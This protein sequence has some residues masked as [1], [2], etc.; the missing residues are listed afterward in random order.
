VEEGTEEF[1]DP[2][3]SNR[4]RE[5]DRNFRPEEKTNTVKSKSKTL[6]KTTYSWKHMDTN[7]W[8]HDMKK[9]LHSFFSKR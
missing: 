7:E 2:A 9:E 8:F 1:D 5:H 6:R 3:C 4:D